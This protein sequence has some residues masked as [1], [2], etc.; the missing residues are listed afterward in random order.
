MSKS[1]EIKASGI[2]PYLYPVDTLYGLLWYDKEQALEIPKQY[3]YK[4]EW[5][6]CISDCIMLR[7]TYPMPY[8]LNLVWLA[9]VERKFYNLEEVFPQNGMEMVWEEFCHDGVSTFTHIVVGMAPYGNVALWFYGD[10]KSR[11]IAWLEATE[12]EV[13]FRDFTNTSSCSNIDEL[14][15]FYINQDPCVRENLVKNGLP[16]RDLFDSYMKQFIY[17]YV[18]I[19][20]FWEEDEQAWIMND[21]SRLSDNSVSNAESGII[22]GSTE[23]DYIE[24]ALFD[25]THDKLHDGGLMNFHLAG[26]PKKLALMWHIKKSEYTAYFWFEDEEISAIFNRFYGAHPETKTDFM[27]RIDSEKNKYELALYRYGLKEPQVI[28]ESAYQLLVFKNKFEYY[29]SKNYNQPKGAWIW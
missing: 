24:E 28:S 11:L 5:G 22:M 17:R 27:I 26:K 15:D 18:V 9:I 20:G 21:E 16:S 1:F 3:P 25:G 6:Q 10:N 7:D 23:F 14:C 12:A 8:K 13:D 2:A 29:R 19:F 4:G